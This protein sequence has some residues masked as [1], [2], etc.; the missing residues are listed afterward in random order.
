MDVLLAVDGVFAGYGFGE[1]LRGVDLETE[2]RSVTCIIGPNGAGKSTL[3][4]TVSG[5]L[6]PS[7]GEIRFD[8]QS[9]GGLSPR[10]V[11]ELGIVQLP[12]DRGLF[13]FMSVW[14]NLLMGG[15]LIRNRRELKRRAEHAAA[16]FPIIAQRRHHSAGT[17]SGGQQKLVEI[18]RILM[19]QPKL[20]LMD[21]PSMGLD[22]ASRRA[23]FGAIKTLQESGVTILMVEQ[24]ARSGLA[25]AQHGVIMD[26]GRAV[27]RS[28]ADKL[29]SNPEV[30]EMYLGKTG[31]VAGPGSL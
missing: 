11:V 27:L 5:L 29:L 22:A 23:V 24:N 6:R 21:E 4:K 12:Q 19:L 17:L 2:A 18:G 13:P 31:S 3:L 9:I 1:I 7:R 16:A 10:E 15:Y 30:K 26:G 25:F 14:D 8:G 28:A 20:A